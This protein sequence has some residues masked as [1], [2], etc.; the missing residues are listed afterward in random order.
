MFAFSGTSAFPTIQADMKDRSKF[1]F[2]VVW[3]ITGELSSLVTIISLIN[4]QAI[5]LEITL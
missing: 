3:A 1:A 4:D 5:P 2:S